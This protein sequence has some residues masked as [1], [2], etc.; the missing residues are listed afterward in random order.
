MRVAL[1]YPWIYLTSG[2]ERVI[3]ELSGRSRHD[4]TIFTSHYEPQHTFP[5]LAARRIVSS[6]DISVSR[7]IGSVLRASWK[8]LNL[9]LP[10]ENVDALV[11]VCEGI[12][13]LVLFRNSSVPAFCICLTPL[14]LA[15]DPAYRRRV[16]EA[17]M[18]MERVAIRAGTSAF[19]LLDRFAWRSYKRIFCIS[20]EVKNRVLSGNLATPEKLEVAHVGLG[21]EPEAPSD[22][23]EP[24]FLVPGRIMWTKNLDL[25]INA[26]GEF[27]RQNMAFGDFRMVIAGIVDKKSENYFADLR[28]HAESIGNVEFKVFPSDAELADLY[29]RCYGVL[30]TAF[31]EDWGIVPLESLAFGKPVICV[32]SGGPRESV[33]HGVDGFLEPAEPRRFSARM[34]ELAMDPG[35]AASMGRAGHMNVK[36]FS[37]MSFTKRIDDAIDV[38]FDTDTVPVK[39]YP[40]NSNV[41]DVL[42]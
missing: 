15:F 21:F 8:V 10:L 19:T 31:N 23:F 39:E 36:R 4:W 22:V 2:A 18:P 28:R 30:F 20:Q 38:C 6:G 17:R 14:R 35:R 27:R 16:T 7:N 26:F 41:D 37:W 13:D 9:K 40:E 32:D 5:G 42:H 25:A 34:A 33:R 12:G 29:S 11:V 24:F 1:Y 3:L